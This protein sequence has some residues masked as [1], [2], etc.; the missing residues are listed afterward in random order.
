MNHS[1]DPHIKS[2]VTVHDT[3]QGPTVGCDN[4]VMSMIAK[5]DEDHTE[6]LLPLLRRATSSEARAIW[7]E[8]D[9]LG[10]RTELERKYRYGS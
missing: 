10:V 8:A 9:Q 1:H 6:R 3:N 4:I 5:Y 2:D 7:H